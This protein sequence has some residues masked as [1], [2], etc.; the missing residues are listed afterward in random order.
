MNPFSTK[1]SYDRSLSVIANFIDFSTQ[2]IH[3]PASAIHLT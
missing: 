3:P 1:E 2:I